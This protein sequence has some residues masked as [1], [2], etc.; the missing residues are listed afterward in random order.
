MSSAALARYIEFGQSLDE[1]DWQRLQSAVM[2]AQLA[3]L[4]DRPDAEQ[5]AESA[6]VL[7]VFARAIGEPEEMDGH[8]SRRHRRKSVQQTAQT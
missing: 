3:L 6:R 8:Q 1:V 4:R 7:N 2:D 5:Y